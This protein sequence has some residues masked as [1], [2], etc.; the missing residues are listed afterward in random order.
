MFLYITRIGAR[1]L[2]K[3][4]TT[5]SQN[6]TFMDIPIAQRVGG[7][8]SKHNL[9]TGSATINFINIISIRYHNL[10][11]LLATRRY[12]RKQHPL[13]RRDPGKCSPYKVAVHN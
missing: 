8:V 3:I 6:K 9:E 11:N 13:R 1:D 5:Y 2:Q 7:I 10:L 4:S 12:S